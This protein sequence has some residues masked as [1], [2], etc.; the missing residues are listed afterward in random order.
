KSTALD[1]KIGYY[2]ERVVLKA[3]M[4]GLNTCWAAMTFNK[5]AIK[6]K[7]KIGKDE[8]LVCVLALGYGATQ[9]K[10]RKSKT[11]QAVCK[12][13]GSLP[14]W[15]QKGIECALLAPTAMNQQ[16]FAFSRVDHKVSVKATKGFYSK[17]DL[18]IVKYHFEVGAE[19]ETF[20]WE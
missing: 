15:Y 17:V 14:A 5:G 6:S 16:A 13:A 11:I 1:E 12:E 19:S 7:L 18:G 10:P 3:Q 4:L 8:K 2:G 9:G 20:E